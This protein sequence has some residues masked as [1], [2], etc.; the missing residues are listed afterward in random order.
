MS[1]IFGV[2]CLCLCV[3]PFDPQCTQSK[4]KVFAEKR[5]GF[6]CCP[7]GVYLFEDEQIT[8]ASHDVKKCDEATVKEM[9]VHEKQGGGQN[10]ARGFGAVRALLIVLIIVAICRILYGHKCTRG[11]TN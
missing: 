4:V 9:P 11:S 6:L 5:F 10:T 2:L 3:Q 7:E 8:A 1:I